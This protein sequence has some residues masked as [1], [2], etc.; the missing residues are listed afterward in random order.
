MIARLALLIAPFLIVATLSLNDSRD[1]RTSYSNGRL[2]SE[3]RYHGIRR[4]VELREQE[5]FVRL[6]HLQRC[7]SVAAL[8]ESRHEP[9]S[10]P[11]VPRFQGEEAPPPAN[12]GG[13]I[14][15]R[16]GLASERL[17]RRRD[18]AFQIGPLLLYPVVQLG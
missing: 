3:R 17:D 5:R 1:V 16:V 9:R 18:A 10:N 6:R 7:R 2:S 12:R 4:R 14:S 11:G 13:M 15:A 8:R